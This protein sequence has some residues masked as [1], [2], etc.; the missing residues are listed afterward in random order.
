MYVPPLKNI[1]MNRSGT[2]GGIDK[3]P[4][5]VSYRGVGFYHTNIC[6]KYMM[7][8]L[9]LYVLKCYLYKNNTVKP[10]FFGLFKGNTC[11]KLSV[12]QVLPFVI[13]C[14]LFI[15]FYNFYMMKRK[16]DNEKKSFS[17]LGVQNILC[18]IE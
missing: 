17:A 3:K 13:K 6:K 16:N 1:K 11:E 5:K 10:L 18:F 2:V 4:Y 8:F 14:Y 9:W 7:L 15:F 12:T